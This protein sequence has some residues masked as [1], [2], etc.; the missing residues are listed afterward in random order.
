MNPSIIRPVAPR[1]FWV[2]HLDPWVVH[3]SGNFGIRWYGLAYLAGIVIA[4]LVFMRW[5]RQDRLPIATDDVGTLI[6]YAA[7]GVI[8]GGR[9]GYCVFYNLHEVV[10]HPLET[11]A[12]W[13]GGMA[14]HGG[15]LGLVLAICLFAWPRRL[16]PWIFVDATA[17]IG[18]VGI[19]F[20]R[21]AN[22]ANGEL[23]GRPSRVAWAVV[24]PEAPL[25]GGVNVP[26][27]PSQL[28]A[29][30]IEGLLLLAVASGFSIARCDRGSLL[31]PCVSATVL[32]ASSMSSGVNPI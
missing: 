22:F 17:A 26:R 14:S 1:H 20:G 15:I 5:A 12:V 9:I 28:Y 24:F 4:A 32:G 11:F 2:D 30:I 27:H 8:F 7:T 29:A 13:H 18:P 23:W 21:L 3:I 19:F 16:D 31:P 6:T 10:L 25:V